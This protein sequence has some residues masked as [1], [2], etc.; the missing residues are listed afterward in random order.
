MKV[1]LF[2]H[3]QLSNKKREQLK[4]V[5]DLGVTDGKLVAFTAIRNC[6]SYLLPTEIVEQEGHR[7]LNKPATDGGSGNDMD[8][9]IRHIVH[10]GH[11]STMEHISFTFALEGVSRALMAQLTRHRVGFSYSIESQRYV[12][13]GSDSK[14]GGF[15]YSS[16]V[17]LNEE[18]LEV[19]STYMDDIQ[20]MYNK[21]IEMKVKPEDARAILPQSVNTNIVM[22][23]N[24]TSFLSFY[25][26][27]KPGTHAQAEIQELAVKMRDEILDVE[28][29]LQGFFE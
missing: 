4:D 2:S 18:Q 11:T 15:T 16:P 28:P 24:L 23:C 8:R 1:E 13:Y 7:Y 9:L 5:L 20:N 22:T 12:N 26:K 29:W 17:S 25:S 6:Y 19:F 27:R 3:T 10:S 14:S 21:L